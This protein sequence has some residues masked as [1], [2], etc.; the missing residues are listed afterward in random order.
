MNK[1]IYICALLILVSSRTWAAPEAADIANSMIVHIPIPIAARGKPLPI[2]A[3]SKRDAEFKSV[4][5][6][7]KDSSSTKGSRLKMKMISP[8]KYQA[9]I[10]AKTTAAATELVYRIEAETVLGITSKTAWYPVK[11]ESLEDKVKDTADNEAPKKNAG[12]VRKFVKAHP[13]ATGAGALITIG[14][15][16]AAGSGG[17]SSSS[18]DPAVAAAD[19]SGTASGSTSAPVV[20]N[21]SGDWSYI[22]PMPGETIYGSMH[23]SQ[24]GTKISGSFSEQG[25]SGSISGSVSGSSISMRLNFSTGE[26]DQLSAKVSG[27]T[28]SGSWLETDTGLRGSFTATR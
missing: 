3:G 16:I 8:G 27:N 20:V 26:I 19:T 9:I 23:L 5:V 25:E 7:M 17:G 14:G 21:V 15:G 1:I 6:N 12:K 24:S 10:P 28:M 22:N 18:G 4:T 11:L 2:M 13:I